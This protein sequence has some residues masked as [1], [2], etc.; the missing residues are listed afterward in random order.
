MESI[1]KL[2]IK[3]SKQVNEAVVTCFI[4]P[5]TLYQKFF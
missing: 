1:C 3:T 2:V 5:G 4:V